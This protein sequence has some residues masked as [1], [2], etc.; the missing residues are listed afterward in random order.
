MSTT[1]KRLQR[2]MELRG[3]K[4]TDLVE[5]TGISKGA[6]SSYISGRYIPKQNNTFLIAKALNVN[7]AWLMGADVP[8]ERDNYED[9]NVLTYYA[10]ESDAEEL[11]KQAGYRI[12]DSE[13]T[14]IVT[15][16]NSDQDIICALHEY[17]LVGI[18]QSLIKNGTLS[19]QALITEAA[20]G[21]KKIDSYIYGKEASGKVYQKLAK[22]ILRFQGNQKELNEVYLQLSSDN[23]KKVLTYS[24]NLLSTQKM[25]EDVLAAHTRTD[26]EHT[27]E[28]IQHDLDIMNDDSEWEE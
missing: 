8:M 10:L 22:N 12:I 6:L 21:W 26:V 25:E 16:T 28:G 19:A 9:Q 5:K 15:I 2:A 23:Q 14:D 20:S 17:E 7:E 27:Q 24:Q 4:Q 1:S 11:L 3:L 18:Y 13:D